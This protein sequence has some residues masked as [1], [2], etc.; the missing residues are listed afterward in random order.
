[1]ADTGETRPGAGAAD[2]ALRARAAAVIPG[3]M[4]GHMN[5]ASLPA[6]F[7]QFFT[8]AEGCRL[9]DADG[10]TY[11]DF[12]CGFGPMIL[13]YGDPGVRAAV[14]AAADAGEIMTGPAPLL[15]DLA[16]RLVETVPHAD[17]AMFQ[18]NGTD[19]TTACVT[20][21][22]AGTG[23]RKVLV[24]AGAYHGAAP[25]CT[26]APA[27]VTPEDRA[28]LLRFT[29]NDIASLE[30]ATET[31]GSDL[32]A[33]VVSP[34]RHDARKDQAMVDPAFAR[35]CRAV[36]D[37]TGAALVLD[38]VRAGF[39]LHPGG[40]WET[41]GVRPDLSAWSK[42]IANGHPLAAVTGNDRFRDAARQVYLTGSFW[43]AAA[44]MAAAL[45]TIERLN[46]TDAV[47]HMVR[48]GHRLREGL[49]AQAAWRG[50]G[51]RQTGPVQMPMVLFDD[52]ADL[53][54]GN[55]FV[56]EALRRGVYLHPW[57][58]MFL[59]LAHSEADIDQALE[60]TDAAMAEVAR[61]FG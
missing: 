27:G 4:W 7:P 10:K 2:R 28:H 37:R 34:F 60:A 52:D 6:G 16:E 35:A 46:A 30:A 14:A 19:A 61:R 32:A 40:S 31:A 41:V 5:A 9:T 23:R 57:H 12:V 21:A 56:T 26:P 24:A 51:L 25:W 50:I 20:I 8:R 53:A 39:R 1:M 18:K 17:W 49:A 36:C 45:A 33:L 59:S 58:N 47:G 54:K 43:C 44:P 3:G 48:V 42:A 38:D 22:R 55:L 29:Y 13:G 11:I 15:V